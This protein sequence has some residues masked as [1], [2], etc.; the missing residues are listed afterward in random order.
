MHGETCKVFPIKHLVGP[1]KVIKIPVDSIYDEYLDKWMQ[2]VLQIGGD[3]GVILT[4]YPE[5]YVNKLYPLQC[6][7]VL[8]DFL[9]L[10]S[11][12]K[13]KLDGHMYGLW[14]SVVESSDR[15]I[16]SL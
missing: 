4:Y 12:A 11:N 1:Y 9:Q 14:P 13:Q 7:I 16:K 8:E 15:F 5:N 2:P 3:Q 10:Y 6:Y